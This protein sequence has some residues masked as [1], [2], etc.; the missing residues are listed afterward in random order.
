MAGMGEHRARHPNFTAVPTLATYMAA[1]RGLTSRATSSRRTGMA[2][3][4]WDG[5]FVAT[6]F[7][8]G[9]DSLA[10]H[11]TSDGITIRKRA[12]G[13]LKHDWRKTSALPSRHGRNGGIA[14]QPDAA[15]LR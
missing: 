4:P 1:S 7:A 3:V 8:G 5:G 2:I 12:G 11:A 15:G 13:W 14:V 9:Q 6:R 10:C